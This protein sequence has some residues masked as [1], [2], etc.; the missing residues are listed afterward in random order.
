M[1]LLN[2]IGFDHANKKTIVNLMKKKK[3]MTFNIVA[4]CF[5]AFMCSMTIFSPKQF[6]EG[7]VSKIPWFKNIPEDPRHR[8]YYNS[9]FLA[10]VCVC[11]GIVPT[12]L[13]PTSG[14]LCLQNTILFFANLMH[15]VVFLG[16]KT[17]DKIRPDANTTSYFQWIFMTVITAAFGIW[18]ILSYEKNTDWLS[19]VA[20]NG[21]ISVQTANIV[22]IV[23]SSGFRSSIL[24]DATTLAFCLLGR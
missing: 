16:S 20:F 6:M 12:I 7:G 5:M 13:S 11:G 2:F 22:G 4:A 9:V 1:N 10:I 21:P 19:S 18:G 24:I 8:V 23:F 14:L 3:K 17:Y 15:V